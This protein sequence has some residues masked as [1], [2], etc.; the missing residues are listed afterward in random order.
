MGWFGAAA[1]VAASI[2][3]YRVGNSGLMWSAIIATVVSFWSWGIMHNQAVEAAKARGN[4]RGGFFDL[5]ERDLRAVSDR[6]TLLNMVAS[7]AAVGFLITSVIL[8]F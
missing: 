1:G 5:T 3:F 7:L 2:L 6:L 8:S 4:Y